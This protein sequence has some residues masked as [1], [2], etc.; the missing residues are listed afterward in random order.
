M[1]RNI[2]ILF[3][4]ICLIFFIPSHISAQNTNV[5]TP[6]PEG[7]TSTT[8][9][10]EKLKCG[11]ADVQ[12]ATQC[13]TADAASKV[14]L[15]QAF[16]VV[17][18]K[19]L[20]LDQYVCLGDLAKDVGSVFSDNINEKLTEF[21]KIGNDPKAKQQ[22]CIVGRPQARLKPGYEALKI[23]GTGGNS[24]VVDQS[25]II[26]PEW[27][28]AAY[29]QAPDA[30]TSCTCVSENAQDICGYYHKKDTEDF[31]ACSACMRLNDVDTKGK[32]IY[33][34][35]GCVNATAEGIVSKLFGFGIGLAG[36][37]ALL[38]IIYASF[39]MQLSRGNPEK[40]KKAQ[41]LLTSCIT[42]L[43]IIIFSVFILRVIG[44]DLLKIPGFGN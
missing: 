27:A 7:A 24:Y 30:L 35:I 1:Q 25:G 41:E 12:E 6:T 33:T 13:C 9:I 4:F 22:L 8:D 44:V 11:F 19:C 14:D 42:G 21:K 38:C 29:Q 17:P 32:Y 28:D 31:K 23:I 43:I 39:Q 36:G 16:N 34:A 26:P 37:V 20:I 3:L 5:P 40:I 2:V 15:N 10:A 18:N